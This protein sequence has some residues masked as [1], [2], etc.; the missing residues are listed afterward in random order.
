MKYSNL[1]KVVTI[2]L[3]ALSLSACGNTEKNTLAVLANPPLTI[4]QY[5]TDNNIQN[6]IKTKEGMYIQIEKEGSTEKPTVS[7]DVTIHYRGYLLDH[8]VFDQTD[9]DAR[10][11]PLSALIAGWKIGIP[12][13]G[14]GGKCKLIIPPHIGYGSRATGDIPANSILVFDIE[15]EDFK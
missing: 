10:T 4:E 6:A 3:I 12:Y 9:G 7:N 15:L 13:I 5:I 8:T 14:K 2:F 11:F 1:Q